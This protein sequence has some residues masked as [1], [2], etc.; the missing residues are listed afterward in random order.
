MPRIQEIGP[1]S[2]PILFLENQNQSELQRFSQR[3]E[4]LQQQYRRQQIDYETAAK[5][6]ADM[7][8]E[9]DAQTEAFQSNM[10]MMQQSQKFVDLGL[11]SPED[12]QEAMWAQVLPK[13]LHQ[14]MY[15]KESAD[16]QRVPFSPG[17]MENYQ[18]TIEEFTKSGKIKKYRFGID[19]LA[20][21]I[22][23]QK[24]LLKQYNTWKVNIGYDAMTSSQQSQVDNEWDAWVANKRTLKKVWNPESKE[25]KA[26]R[27]KGLLTRG[28]GS[29]V[30]GTPLGPREA[31][32]PIQ[33]SI[34][35]SLPKKKALTEDVVRSLLQETNNNPAEAR[36]LAKERGYTQ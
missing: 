35:A 1:A 25:V 6:I 10:R 18:E 19:R 21:D 17:Q 12:S 5:E 30:R 7:Q 2:T 32:N 22:H 36:R 24:S 27:G 26:A 20:K 14:K 4:D 13:E 33:S 31:G 34:A 16:P 29:P 8:A 11:V 15:P 9:S 23:T 3:Y 28:Y